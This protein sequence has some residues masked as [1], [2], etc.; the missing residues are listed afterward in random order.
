MA[1]SKSWPRNF[2]FKKLQKSLSRLVGSL[3]VDA[4]QP[5]KLGRGKVRISL[6]ALPLGLS[7][8]DAREALHI[9]PET[10][11]SA[12]GQV[13]RTGNVQLLDPL[14]GEGVL[15]REL[16]LAPGQSVSLGV[17]AVGRLALPVLGGK[18]SGRCVTI[19]AFDDTLLLD[20]HQGAPKIRVM[21]LAVEVLA[22]KVERRISALRRLQELLGR[23]IEPAAPDVAMEL[24]HAVN[25]V[26][27]REGHRP[28]DRRGMPGG[29]VSLPKRLI[30]VI[31]GD[32]HG[33]IDNLLAILSRDA[34]LESLD[35]GNACLI[36]LGDA[37]HPE[38]SGQ[39]ESM[40]SSLAIMDLLFRLKLRFPERVFYLRGNHDGFSE[41]IVRDGV[42]QGLV[43]RKAVRKA[44]GKDYRKELER[45]YDRIPYMAVSKHF[46]AC[47][48][49]APSSEVT[50]EML[51]DVRQYPGLERELTESW[52]GTAHRRRGYTRNDV[53]RLRKAMGLGANVP[54]VVGHTPL[55]QD[56]TLW[57]D[58]GEIAGHHVV[59][60]GG[61]GWVGAITLSGDGMVP[62]RYPA[63]PLLE[64]FNNL[65]A[66]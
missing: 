65:T 8:G 54:F 35:S 21:P 48:A 52:R 12:R 44:R 56:D 51:I 29:L 63:E 40:D 10:A 22:E 42:A 25:S 43:W 19:K 27:E 36:V 32:L 55:S 30:P 58:V 13:R 59:Y 53:K 60:S 17:N 16:R 26:L 11:L 39:L 20:H 15:R 45:F 24:L 46:I 34:L 1:D 18:G 2:P 5:L 38:E 3:A 64:L 9:Y 37:I 7:F 62:L 49:G 6:D 23:P 28:T 31:V 41:D 61:K 14:I 4:R 66:A 50:R 47:H 33:R 57:R